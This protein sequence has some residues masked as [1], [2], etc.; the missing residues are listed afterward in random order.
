V[1]AHGLSASDADPTLAASIVDQRLDRRIADADDA[2]AL[3]GLPLLGQI[4]EAAALATPLPAAKGGPVLPPLAAA[5]TDAF[6]VLRTS[7]SYPDSSGGSA[8]VGHAAHR[9]RRR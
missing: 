4:P 8:P 6:R 2:A 5:E 3:H 7:I 9:A 1:A